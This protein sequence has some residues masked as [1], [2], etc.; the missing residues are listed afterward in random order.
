[1]EE[2]EHEGTVVLNYLNARRRGVYRHYY[3]FT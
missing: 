1:M 3:V 2:G